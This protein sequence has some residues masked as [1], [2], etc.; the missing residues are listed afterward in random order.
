[1]NERTYRVL[2]ACY[3]G[4]HVQSLIP[5]A[6]VLQD[7]PQVML[8]V[9]GFTTARAT[10]ERAGIKAKGYTVLEGYLT[11]SCAELVEPF[12]V[13]ASHP[14]VSKVETRAYFKVGLHDLIE[15]HG[16]DE[17][18]RLVGEQG[19]VAFQPELTFRRYLEATF[20][21]LVITSTSPRSELALQRAARAVGIP[22]LA[23]SDLFLQHEAA[24]LCTGKYAPHI[25]VI[26]EYVAN[27]LRGEGCSQ[28]QLHVTGN[29]AFDGLFNVAARTAGQRIRD[30]FQLNGEIRLI[31]WIGTP[32]EVS[33]RGKPFV[34]NTEIIEHL[35]TF[36]DAHPG[37]KFA[38]RPHP[39]R[40]IDFP[41][42]CRHGL[43]LGNEFSIEGVLW[44]SDVVVL[45]T[46]TVGLQAAL[47][48]RP[49]I[50]INSDSYPPYAALG[51]AKDVPDLN[52]LDDALMDLRSPC[53]E[54]L[55]PAGLGD[56]TARVL[57]IIDEL[58]GRNPDLEVDI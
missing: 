48:G 24:Y 16:R 43:L 20:P 21:D 28:T 57:R 47:I 13:G 40:S 1:M 49:V 30:R 17:A 18:L 45:E 23:V 50:T 39:N 14:D 9:L 26:A 36:C 55:G 54:R 42:N 10:F 44:A 5:I 46:S 2:L 27:F 11:H 32:N 15:A 41:D 53:L 37:Y 19:R 29:P 34:R 4:G 6:R 52:V 22:G 33:L 8:T 51:L 3:G 35:D 7:D 25:S 38:F 12:I 58:L 31:T 56:A